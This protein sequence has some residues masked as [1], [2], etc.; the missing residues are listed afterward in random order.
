M[1]FL[2]ERGIGTGIHYPKPIYQQK[3]YQELGFK[4]FCTEAESASSEVL[5]LPVQPSLEKSELEEIVAALM[6]FSKKF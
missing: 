6:E 2:K 4:G 3:I 5:S 1:E